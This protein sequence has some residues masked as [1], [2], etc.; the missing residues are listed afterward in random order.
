MN[1]PVCGT[2]RMNDYSVTANVTTELGKSD[3]ELT[4]FT[5]VATCEGCKSGIS[6]VIPLESEICAEGELRTVLDI[7]RV[8][9]DE[10]KD[11][12]ELKRHI[13]MERPSRT[14]PRNYPLPER[15]A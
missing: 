12:G 8:N 9:M 7:A 4:G 2:D 5:V 1:C 15:R 6:I 3:A 14:T 13:E 10:M 11:S